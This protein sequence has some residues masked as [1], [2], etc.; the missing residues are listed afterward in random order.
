MAESHETL[1]RAVTGLRDRLLKVESKVG[2]L[3]QP[4]V[5]PAPPT[6]V[7]PTSFLGIPP[8]SSVIVNPGPLVPPPD[9]TSIITPTFPSAASGT[10]SPG[11]LQPGTLLP[12]AL[13]PGNQ[14]PGTLP[15]GN[16]LT[17]PGGVSPRATPPVRVSPAAPVNLRKK[18]FVPSASTPLDGIIA[19]LTE[20]AGGNVHDCNV[21]VVT[22]SN[23]CGPD[24]C[25]AA[26]NVVDLNSRSFFYSAYRARSEDIPHTRNNWICYDFGGLKIVPTHYVL[27]SCNWTGNG[28][29][30]ANLKSW[31]VE[32]SL[33]GEEWIEIGHK[34]DNSAMN[35]SNAI[36]T[37][38]VSRSEPCRFIRLVNIGR[39]HAGSDALIISAFEIFG[40]I[41]E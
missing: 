40:S 7:P 2:S 25:Y 22:S 26:K 34:E 38:G 12:G 20:V 36:R 29:N 37:F 31:V 8:V 14:W 16:L 10:L 41:V 27:R 18:K 4:S 3:G 23:P 9:L 1:K 35:G 6:S 28:E 11:N 15:P 19:Y 32:T 30:C 17:P 13:P 39:N 33:D 21:V 5:P 24:H